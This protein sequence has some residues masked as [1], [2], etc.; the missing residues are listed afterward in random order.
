M[1]PQPGPPQQKGPQFENAKA[2]STLRNG[3]VLED[4]YKIREEEGNSNSKTHDDERGEEEEL[5]K[6]KLGKNDKGKEKLHENPISYQSRVPFPSA[7]EPKL[8]KKPMKNEELLEL[9]QQVH[10]NIPLIDAI[11]H[12]PTYVKFLKEL[13][14]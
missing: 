9:F 7:L 13:C 5:I 1:L 12:V 14:T 10:I 6:K 3:R 11:K 2:I 4:P 8:K